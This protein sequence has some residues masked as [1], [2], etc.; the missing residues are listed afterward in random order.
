MT[1]C[2]KFC[3]RIEL[4][5]WIRAWSS[6]SISKTLIWC[7]INCRGCATLL[8]KKMQ[9]STQSK[10]WSL[11]FAP[12]AVSLI[13]VRV[14]PGSLFS[15]FLFLFTVVISLILDLRYSFKRSAFFHQFH[16]KPKHKDL[17]GFRDLRPN[18]PLKKKRS[19]SHDVVFQAKKAWKSSDLPVSVK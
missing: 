3:A 1:E 10:N 5:N 9:N 18:W 14:L 2:D 19:G 8:T 13:K 12:Q 7:S 4:S 16:T 17:H 6:H 11:E 15:F